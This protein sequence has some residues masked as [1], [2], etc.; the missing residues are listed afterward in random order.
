MR[1]ITE[2][3]TVALSYLKHGKLQEA[4][5]C[6]EEMLRFQPDNANALHFLGIIYY[7]RKQ[8]DLA[9]SYIKKAL[10]LQ[11]NYFDAYNNLGIVLQEIGQFDEAI[12]YYQQAIQVNPDSYLPYYNLGNLFREKKQI[13]KAINYYRKAL[14]ANPNLLEAYTQLGRIFD[15]IGQLEL[16]VHCYKYALQ[17]NPNLVDETT[18]V[19]ILLAKQSKLDEAEVYFKRALQINPG[20]LPAYH[21]L[22]FNMCHNSKHDTPTIFH[23]HKKFAE[24]YEKL[25]CYS[26]YANDCDPDRKIRI[27]YISPDF[28]KHPVSYFLEP[29]LM[30]HNKE[31]FEVYCYSNSAV[32]DKVTKRFREYSDHWRNIAE[33]S[34]GKAVELIRHDRID[35]L[36]D[37][38]GHTAKNRL[39][40][41]AMKPAPVQICWIG[42]LATTG[43]STMDY[44]ISDNYA[45]PIGMTEQFYSEKLIRLPKCFLCYLPDRNSP[46]IG[47]LPALSAGHITFGSF[48]KFSKL[49]EEIIPLWS[50]ILKQVPDSF[51]M[52][53]SIADEATI[54]YIRDRFAKNGVKEDRIKV[55]SWDPSPK[56]LE[57]YNLVDIGLDTFPFNGLT[58]T[59]EAMWMGVPV[60]NLVGTAYHSRSGISLLSNVGLKELIAK[61]PAEYIEIAVDLAKDLKRLQ[62]L[63]EGLRDMMKLSPLCDAKGFTANLELY[64][65]QIWNKWCQ[66]F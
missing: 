45:D 63:R 16:G 3:L 55:S 6:Y 9:I 25:S 47:P 21:N 57:S 56:H 43:L 1:K 54:R 26:S 24:Q 52:L 10:F 2:I 11:P 33:M 41:F 17:L 29:V 40:I 14:Q 32:E 20:F 23:E 51:L 60:I 19:G 36:I 44:K 15:D 30:S 8:Y 59:C 48:N 50:M 28:I 62:S 64:Y 65:R 39:I 34:D 12:T 22:L 35:I 46:E 4:E 18:N 49:S 37:L 53:K 61:T 66:F 58:T 13:E 42:Y 38:A 5:Q 7:R 27:G 31:H